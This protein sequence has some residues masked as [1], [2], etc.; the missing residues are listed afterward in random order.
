M[1]ITIIKH[2]LLP[3]I[4]LRN[5]QGSLKTIMSPTP[6][7]GWCVTQP[8]VTII[9]S[10]PGIDEVVVYRCY[11]NVTPPGFRGVSTRWNLMRWLYGAVTVMS[12]P[13]GIDV[14]VVWCCY[15]NVTPPGFYG[16]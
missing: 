16:M 14:V 15:N 6:W 12:S 9:S 2:Y 3:Y 8:E 7:V 11:S 5:N 4:I 10:P 13:L 1:R